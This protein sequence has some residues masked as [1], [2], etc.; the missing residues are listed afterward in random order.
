MDLIIRKGTIDDTDAF[1]RL[2]EEVRQGMDNK[3]WF[4]LDPPD[5]V[6]SMMKEGSMQLW[7]AMDGE[8]MAGAFD[9]LSPGLDPSNY[10]WDLA[11]SEDELLRVVHMDTAA[12]HPEYRGHGLQKQLMQ[13]AEKAASAMESRILL[14]T[15]HP[16][17]CFSLNNILQQGYDI[18]RQLPKYGSVRYILRKD[19]P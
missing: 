18:A 2:L 4:Y 16:E 12:V 19:L 14:T 3:E 8:R 11:F 13:E 17:N 9:I 15:V 6:R 7:V 10:G 1:I 5:F